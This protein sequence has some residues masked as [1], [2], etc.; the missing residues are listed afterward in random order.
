MRIGIDFSSASGTMTGVGYYTLNLV[1]NLA[2]IDKSNQYTL[3]TSFYG[4]Y[5]PKFGKNVL[6]C[7]ENFHVRFENVP[8]Q[9]VT[10][11][12]FSP[13]PRKWLLGDIDILHSP[14][15]RAPR[16]HPG[17]LIV[18]LH[19]A[20]CAAVPECQTEITRR[21]SLKATRD[22]I[23]FAKYI[24][25]DSYFSKSELV[26][27]F[28][29]DPAQIT[30]IHLAANDI[31][32][33]AKRMDQDRVL[34]KYHLSRDYVLI[35]GTCEPRKNIEILVRAYLHLPD[36]L[37]K[38]YPLVIV[39]GTG[40]LHTSDTLDT[41]LSS[42]KT[43]TIH[44][45]GYVDERDLPALYSAASVFV[46]PSLYEG[47][48]LPV[49]EAMACGTPVISS[50]SSSLPEVGGNAAL[51]FD[52][53]NANQLKDTLE[54]LLNDES[55]CAQL[56]RKGIEHSRQFTWEKTARETLGVYERVYGE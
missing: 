31:F 24:I 14:I 43:E 12:W 38:K 2:K 11:L 10:G 55:M 52:P 41:M 30:V 15:F 29:A 4:S 26:K 16:D 32:T 21:N 3:Y 47:F 20:S 35:V 6:P 13:V 39:G 5:P 42:G 36:I 37:K 9:I 51:Y 27:Y 34:S 19:D 18:T 22:A 7:Q 33:P 17:K 8:K 46:F 53:H 49:L 25:T 28:N 54:G 48:G 40:W 56:S 45:L 1:K 23:T 44:R 50:N